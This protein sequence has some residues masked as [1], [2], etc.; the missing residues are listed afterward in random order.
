MSEKSGKSVPDDR[1][2]TEKQIAD[3]VP[4]VSGSAV[5]AVRDALLRIVVENREHS[6]ILDLLLPKL[7][8]M[9]SKRSEAL[10][11]LDDDLARLTDDDI[12]LLI[13][14]LKSIG[15]HEVLLKRLRQ[16]V[17]RFQVYRRWIMPAAMFVLAIGAFGAGR[18]WPN[19]IDVDAVREEL[20][21]EMR[22]ELE[23][24]K[25]QISQ[26]QELNLWLIEYQRTVLDPRVKDRDQRLKNLEAMTGQSAE[27]L[28]RLEDETTPQ[29]RRPEEKP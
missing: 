15:G 27:M 18:V 5:D 11:W 2:R 8:Q 21:R 1:Q 10:D 23:D 24:A 19:P 14:R 29:E 12:I 20:T 16:P 17:P 22:A 25:V 7:E 9:P 6:E 26:L 13:S 4:Y 28:R 3:L